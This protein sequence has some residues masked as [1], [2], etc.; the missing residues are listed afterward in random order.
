M[1]KTIWA[2]S[3]NPA[4][5]IHHALPPPARRR[6]QAGASLGNWESSAM[7]RPVPN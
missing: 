2:A 3:G 5:D 6:G 4:P 1:M 7:C